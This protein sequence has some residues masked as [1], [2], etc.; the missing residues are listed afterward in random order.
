MPYVGSRISLISKSE[1]RYEG[2]LYVINTE[3]S[4]IALQNVRS[5]GTEGRAKPDVPPTDEVYD[6]IIF[7]GE[8]IKDLTVLEGTSTKPSQRAV[9]DDPAVVSVGP[10]RKIAQQKAQ[11]QRESMHRDQRGNNSYKDSQSDRYGRDQ[12]RPDRKW[13]DGR[14]NRTERKWDEGGKGRVD[15]KYEDRREPRSSYARD[16]HHRD[17]INRD[18]HNQ[19]RDRKDAG[20]YRGHGKNG[21]RRSYANGDKGPIGELTANENAQLKAEIGTEEFDFSS[22]N[23]KFTKPSETVTESAGDDT[24]AGYSK[25][26][27]FFDDISCDALDRAGGKEGARFDR[28]AR[29]KQRE[30]DKETFGASALTRPFGFGGQRRYQKGGKGKAF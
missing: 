13:D 11:P 18:S 12:N 9:L 30:V 2:I 21:H 3:E 5:Y 23:E 25:T 16:N 6:F 15:R 7:R 28:S 14:Y 10:E 24:R 1:I 29:D 8:D 17:N 19:G 26:K 22:A 20:G 4:T 27:S